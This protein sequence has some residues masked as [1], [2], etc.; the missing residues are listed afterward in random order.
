[1]QCYMNMS[2]FS[3]CI[4]ITKESKQKLDALRWNDSY[5]LKTQLNKNHLKRRDNA[6]FEGRETV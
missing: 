4:Q 6:K 1:M 2:R 5:R 3:K